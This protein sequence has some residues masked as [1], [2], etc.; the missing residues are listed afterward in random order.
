LFRGLSPL[1]DPK[2]PIYGGGIRGGEGYTPH[3]G[4]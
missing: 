2:P 4:G 3:I 1:F